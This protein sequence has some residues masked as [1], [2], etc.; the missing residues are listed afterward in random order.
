M[1]EREPLR[2]KSTQPTG[3]TQEAVTPLLSLDGL[4][5]SYGSHQVIRDISHEVSPGEVVTL[6][7]PSGAGKSTLLRCINYLETPT[8]GTIS[9]SGKP[10]SAAPPRI[11]KS[12]LLALRRHVGMVFQNFN[13]FPHL[14]VLR[15]ITLAQEL[16]LGRNRDEAVE[17]AKGLLDRVGLTSK[18]NAHPM[19][20]SGGQQQRIA[21]ARALALDP[22]LMLFDEP[23]SALDPEIG[24]E[25]LAVMKELAASGMTMMIVTH[26]MG[27]ARDV[28][29]TVLFLADGTILERGR[30][31]QVFDNPQHAR[32]RQFLKA[33]VGR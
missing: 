12:E 7:G 6:I 31:E 13:L 29:D 15:N 11:S 9:L 20:C 26:E 33:V 25:V 24:A 23:T 19:E 1:S 18:M 8:A 17:R 14:T 10:V 3:E 28:S 27:F 32:T 22:D 2:W 21:I 16:A 4:S 30:P 5:K